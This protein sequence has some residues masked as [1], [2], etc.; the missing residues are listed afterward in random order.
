MDIAALGL[1][2]ELS[3]ADSAFGAL[4]KLSEQALKTERSLSGLES[5]AGKSSRSQS[6]A[7]KSSNQLSSSARSVASASKDGATGVNN[8]SEANRSLATTASLA[9]ASLQ[10]FL[11]LQV[12]SW[13]KGATVSIYQASSAA[14]RLRIGLDFSSVRGSANEINYLRETT[15]KLG[16][17]FSGTAGAYQQFQASARG[18]AL[19]GDK[20][21]A[22]FEA[23]SK[24]SAVMGLS[25]DQSSG[26]LLALQQMV[27]K[28]T[29][30]AEELRG[31]LGERLPG[32]FQT[33]ARAMGVTTA[34]LGKML[35]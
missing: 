26:A 32:A 34:E 4:S 1:K 27:S 15:D 33:A 20:A 23:V 7:A 2:V 31:Q 22:V 21:R 24:A 30:Q 6:E 17:S 11:G 12:V 9:T 19:E 14:E 16:L 13:A 8:F 29:V 3:G 28:G 25:A 5:A 10:A 18:T 35:E